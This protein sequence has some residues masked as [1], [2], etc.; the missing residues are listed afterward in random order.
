MSDEHQQ[1]RQQEIERNLAFF[2]GQ[3]PNIPAVQAGKYALIRHQ[4]II[5][6]FDTPLDA[7]VAARQYDDRIY[8]I[9]QVTNSAVNLGFFSH[10]VPLATA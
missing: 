6:Y 1:T 8:S 2:L 9:Q 10:A 5:G 7:I 4:N 3:L